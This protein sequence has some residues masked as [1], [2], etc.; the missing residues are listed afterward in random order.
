M[1]HPADVGRVDDDDL[2]WINLDSRSRHPDE[3]A[4]CLLFF[5]TGWRGHDCFVF[6]DAG[7]PVGIGTW[8]ELEG[9]R[10]E[11]PSVSCSGWEE[12]FAGQMTNLRS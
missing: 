4:R 11:P 6:D 5:H 12:W 2:V 3:L 9:P 10:G 7:R 1:D 8:S